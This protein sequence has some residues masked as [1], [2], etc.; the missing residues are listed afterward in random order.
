VFPNLKL[1]VLLAFLF[2]S[3]LAVGVAVLRVKLGL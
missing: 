3:L 2:S 1:N